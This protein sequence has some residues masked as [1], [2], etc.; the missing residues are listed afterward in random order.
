[1]SYHKRYEDSYLDDED[2]EFAGD[3]MTDGQKIVTLLQR[4]NRSQKDDAFIAKLTER[5]FAGVK[6]PNPIGV[7]AVE[8]ISLVATT[9]AGLGARN[10]AVALLERLSDTA[11]STG[12]KDMYYKA[13]DMITELGD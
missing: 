12:N 8:G 1:M 9:Y 3:D 5:L 10:S 11:T 13:M 4:E 2:E 6:M 7:N